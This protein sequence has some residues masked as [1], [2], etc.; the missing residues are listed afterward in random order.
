M[1]D[2][3][4]QRDPTLRVAATAGSEAEADLVRQ[5]LAEAGISAVVQ[6]SIG[7]PEWG[8]SGAQYVYVEAGH[9]DRAREILSAP[10]VSEEELARL[11]DE[12]GDDG[13][14]A[15]DH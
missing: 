6:R 12:A 11:S 13:E 8:A 3:Q 15:G 1:S 14:P 2:D 9:L 4:P 5:R 7:G 10:G